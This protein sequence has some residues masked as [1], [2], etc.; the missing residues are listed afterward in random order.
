MRISRLAAVGL[1]ALAAVGCARPGA[2]S[3]GPR[4][5]RPPVVIATE[6]AP[7]AVVENAGTVIRFRFNERVSERP[8]RGT[9]DEAVVVSPRTG[10]VRVGHGSDEVEVRV[11]GGLRPG[12][13]YR[14]T[15]LPVI[16]DLFGNAMRDPFELVFST[17]APF[18]EN[19][20]AGQV[21]DRITGR[22]LP[23]MALQLLPR[24]PAPDTVVHVARSDEAGLYFFR[25]VPP[26]QYDLVALQDRNRNL[27]A[28]PGEPNGRRAVLVR[29]GDTILADIA[30]LAP[31]TSAAQLLR[32]E[33]VDSTTLRLIFSD[34]LDQASV[35]DITVRVEA[36]EGLAAL[37]A[38]R[39]LHPRGWEQL[40]DSLAGVD[41]AAAPG[42]QR[43][44]PGVGET[45]SVPGQERG[46]LPRGLP[47]PEQAVVVTLSGPLVVEQSYRV[48][49]TGVVNVNGL[50]LGRGE[51]S[52]A[53]E[54]PPEPPRE[55]PPD[56]TPAPPGTLGGLTLML[57]L[58]PASGE[59]W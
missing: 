55:A 7:L 27:L 26:G 10:A 45:V 43:R 58:T 12:L 41:G 6:P 23:E 53:R 38:T 20:L 11:E 17:G 28:D 29:E 19:A 15:V 31:D 46:G 50:S 1:T 18:T 22:P 35:G 33:V 13:L 8:A 4:D 25:Y 21:L 37:G 5:E 39:V 54:A 57:P 36:P 14:V 34:Y 51:A 52:V 30:V 56:F 2:P 40:R 42:Q 32:A 9:M 44:V 59:G 48:V 16:V 49:A 24:A 3:G 47:L